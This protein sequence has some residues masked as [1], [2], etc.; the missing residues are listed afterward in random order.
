MV[1]HEK[2]IGNLRSEMKSRR[3]E[4]DGRRAVGYRYHGDRP[5]IQTRNAKMK[6]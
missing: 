1:S 3:A 4:K 2:N 5:E 6:E